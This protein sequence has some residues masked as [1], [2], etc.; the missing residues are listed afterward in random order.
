MKGVERDMTTRAKTR[1]T[2][3]IPLMLSS[4]SAPF[5]LLV[6][7]LHLTVSLVTNTRRRHRREPRTRGDRRRQGAGNEMKSDRSDEA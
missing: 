3:G 6:H 4:S 1:T 2:L 5:P 7:S